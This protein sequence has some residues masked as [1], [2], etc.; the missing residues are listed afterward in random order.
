MG[1]LF[2]TTLNDPDKASN[3]YHAALEAEP[4]NL[5]AMRGLERIYGAQSNWAEMVKVLEQQLDVIATERERIEALMKLALIFE[6]QFLKADEA[7]ARFEQVLD[8]D[9]NHE[10][11]LVGLDRC[12]AKLRQCL[13]L[14]S[15]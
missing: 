7:A 14:V 9:P 6:E 4:S 11:E 12:Y 2:E 3:A 5:L 13:D 10:P 15:T 1:G 8:V